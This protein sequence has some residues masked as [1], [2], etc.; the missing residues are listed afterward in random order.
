MTGLGYREGVWVEPASGRR[1]HYRWWQPP[2][3]QALLVI[4]H[5]LGEHGGRY[6]ALALPLAER[7]I[8]VAAP[9]LWGHGRSGGARGDLGEVADCV[10][11]FQEMTARVLLPASGR[12][13]YSLFGHSFGGLAALRWALDAPEGLHRLVLQSPLLEV[14]FPIPRWKRTSAAVLAGWWP[15]FP[16]STRLEPEALSRD[17]AVVEAYRND[18]LVH[19]SL[20]ARTYRSMTRTRDDLMA[21]AGMLRI[22]VLMLSGGADRIVSVD[23]A[24]RWLALV[25]CEKRSV[26]FPDCYHELHHEPVRDEVIRLTGEWILPHA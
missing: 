13:A 3:V 17:Q 25:N 23:A 11:H 20:S 24:Q 21:R 7:G 10:R 14:G 2:A 19:T 4:V 16:F 8:M 1:Y 22:P 9:D 6:Q 18:P 26:R 12:T 5:G 15:A